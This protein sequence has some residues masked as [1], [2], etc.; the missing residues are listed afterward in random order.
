MRE[1]WKDRIGL[2]R[3]KRETGDGNYIFPLKIRFSYLILFFFFFGGGMWDLS[4][5]TRV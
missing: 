5:L 2:Q 1:T 3:I 4:F